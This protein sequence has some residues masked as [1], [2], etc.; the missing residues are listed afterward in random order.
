MR[1]LFISSIGLAPETKSDFME[2]VGKDLSTIKIGF[3]PTAS[4]VEKNPTYVQA[5][6][7]DIKLY[8]MD[9][10][11]IDL[12]YENV[13]SLYAKLSKV[14]IIM[15]E[16]GNTFYLLD[17]VRKSGFDRIIGKLLDAGKIYYGISAGSYIAC[18]SIEAAT[19][20]DA[21]INTVD[22]K[23]LTGLNLVPFIIS[24]HYNQQKYFDALQDGVNS[25]KYPVV[26]LTDK[27]AIVVSNDKYKII[28]EGEKIFYNGFQESQ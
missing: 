11:I 5:D 27:Q 21:D 8:G 17:W 28:G 10:E 20:K 1:K 2:F 3:I 9:Y 13:D 25:T 22:L 18:P 24:A 4:D 26:A 16:G 23:D 14:D 12:K 15:V 6:I 7:D 19:W